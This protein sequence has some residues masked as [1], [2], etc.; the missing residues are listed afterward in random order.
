MR[1]NWTALFLCLNVLFIEPAYCNVVKDACPIQEISSIEEGIPSIPS[2]AL[3]LFDVDDTLIS[4]PDVFARGN[5]FPWWFRL[6]LWIAHPQLCDTKTWEDIYSLM[7][8]QAPRILIEPTVPAM[9]QKLKDSGHF[10]FALTSMETGAFGVISDMPDWRFQML[11]KMGI[12]FSHD[13]SDQMFDS[14]SSYRQN[15]PGLYRG[16]L[17]ANQ[18][19][20]GAV[21]AAFLD[22]LQLH[23]GSIVFFDDSEGALRSVQDTCKARQIPCLLFHYTGARNLPGQWNTR[24]VLKQIDLLIQNRQW[25]SDQ[26]ICCD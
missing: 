16:I 15:Y 20:K 10:V 21:L 26:N 13:F 6:R 4:S 25:V 7:L 18:Q 23:P 5:Y 2:N 24:K 1:R 12:A 8:S 9:V 11:E 19:P 22:T 17:C 14:L 3:I